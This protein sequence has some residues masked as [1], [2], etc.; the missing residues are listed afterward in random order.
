[1]AHSPV[2]AIYSCRP[3]QSLLY[4]TVCTS[5]QK[6]SPGK[7]AGT[8][9]DESDVDRSAIDQKFWLVGKGALMLIMLIR[10][11][12]AIYG[13]HNIIMHLRQQRRKTEFKVKRFL[14]IFYS[15]VK[16]G[17]LVKLKYSAGIR[18]VLLILTQ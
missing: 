16:P 6:T 17:P 12:P 3:L 9:G 2:T 11:L 1:M 5:L 8:S 18:K 14:V 4:L 10:I 13:Q 7:F 15:S